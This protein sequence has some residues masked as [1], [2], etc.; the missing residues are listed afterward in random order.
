ME[1]LLKRCIG[2]TID[3]ACGTMA[4]YRGEAISVDGG[5]L[6]L[7]DDE[8]KVA[9]IAVEKI[10]VVYEGSDSSTRPGFIV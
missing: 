2:K 6:Q 8:G 7:K 1:E 9:Y 5:I 4:V 3:V 10:S